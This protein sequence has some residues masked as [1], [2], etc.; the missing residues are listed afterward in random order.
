MTDMIEVG[1]ITV[2][3]VRKAIKNIH[4]RVYPPL[5]RVR[6]SAP[7]LMNMDRI[8]VFAVSKLDWIKKTQDKIRELEWV[9]QHEYR[10]QEIH[11]VW[12]RPCVLKV[13]EQ[14]SVPNV[15]LEQN[16]LLLRIRPGSSQEKK[17]AV[18]D[19]WYR[20]Q[21]KTAVPPLVSKWE[22]LMGVTVSRVFVQRMKTRWG[23]CCPRL[24]ALRLN[25]ELAKKPPECLEYVVVHEMAHLQV[26]SH[27]NRFKALMDRYI[28]QWKTYR[29]ILNRR[30]PRNDSWVS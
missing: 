1:D 13:E 29:T 17:A 8:R 22:P 26:S 21:L 30:P 12:G 9:S 19:N 3:V 25:S 7:R 27:N 18:L 6:I 15:S 2:D 5:G 24:K 11:Y 28:P 10:D 4:L 23:T 20:E 14:A 16:N